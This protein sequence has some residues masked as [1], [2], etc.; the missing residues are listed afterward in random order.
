[1]N[2]PVSR[3]RS[4][5]SPVLSRHG[6]VATSQPL[7]AQAGLRVLQAGGNAADAAVV[8]ATV[9]NVVEPASTGA[10][11]DAFALIRWADDGRVRALNGS[12][13]APAAADPEALRAKGWKEIPETSPF[14]ITVPGSVDAWY[15]LLTTYG[16]LSWEAALRPAIQYAE[17]GFPVSPFIARQWSGL[18]SRLQADEEAALVYLAGG[19]GPRA[20]EIRRQPDL[21]RTFRR[22]AER[23]PDEFYR[24]ETAQAIADC[25]QSRG[26]WLDTGDLRNHRST[27][28]EPISTDYRG[29]TVYEHPPNGQGLTA[30]ITLNLVTAAGLDGAEW[31]SIE[32]THLFVEAM[33]LAFADGYRYIADPVVSAVPVKALLAG[34]YAAERGRLISR[35]KSLP[36]PAPGVI[37]P[38][39]DTVYLSVVDGAGNAVSFINSLFHGFGTGIVAPGTGVAL[40]SR[41]CLFRLEP[42]HPNVLAPGKRPYHTIIPAMACRGRELWLSF[43]VVGGFMQPQAHVQV[44]T[45]LLDFGMAPQEALDAPRWCVN[46]DGSLGL[47]PGFPAGVREAMTARGHR[48]AAEQPAFLGEFGC[49]QIIAVEDGVLWGASD[50]RKDGCAV[51]W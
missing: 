15:Q 10:G 14:A 21:A 23:G 25:V 17:E 5:R 32:A 2:S 27:W 11:G 22:I 41:G 50:P 6:M 49:G 35:D 37:P 26:G 1:M 20:G 44:L 24:G 12:G 40:Q 51:G 48:L 18:A 3:F 16:T 8:V 34:E 45:N 36:D 43:G 29:V 28:E 38:A 47:E 9:L 42:D 19:R 39:N 13:R 4:H 31:G 33:K 7:A 30:L 46:Q